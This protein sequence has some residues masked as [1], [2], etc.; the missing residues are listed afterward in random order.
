MPK[1]LKIVSLLVV[2]FLTSFMS[3]EIKIWL[4]FPK[5]VGVIQTC[6][7]Q[8]TEFDINIT[9]NSSK[10][11]KVFSFDVGI[12]DFTLFNDEK[13]IKKTDTLYCNEKHPLKLKGKYKI[14]DSLSVSLFKFK[15]DDPDYLNNEIKVFYGEYFISSKEI[16]DRKEQVISVSE[17]CSDSIRVYFPYGGTVSSASLYNDSTSTTKAYKSICYGFGDANN[18]L[19]FSKAD[20]GRYF[21][22]FGSCHWG[23]DFWLTIK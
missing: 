9:T 19:T 2:V 10:K 12:K 6:N 14:D 11:I 13:E 8:E 7:G 17:S 16:R 23:N 18:H 4:Y 21:V 1:K 22:S 20:V 3:R 15:T 5:Q